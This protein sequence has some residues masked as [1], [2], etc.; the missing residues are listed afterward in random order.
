MPIPTNTQPWDEIF[1]REG[2]VFDSPAPVVHHVAD[3]FQEHRCRRVVDLGCGS[4]RHTVFLAQRGL[5]VI[6]ID[7]SPA[8]LNLSREWLTHEGLCAR[9]ARADMRQ[10]LP[11]S[12]GVCDAVISTQ[13]IHHALLATVR[14]TAR[15]ITRIL[16]PGGVLFVSMPSG[17][18][19]EDTFQEIEPGTFVPISGREAGLPHHIFSAEELESLFSGYTVLEADLIDERIR[20]LLAIRPA[21]N[22]AT[23]EV[24]RRRP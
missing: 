10:P 17:M 22:D 3:V 5:D 20:T 7:S 15:E 8:A 6:G 21:E 14:G 13:V 23:V 19:T 4:G 11:L 18:D 12:G 2:R 16:R 1:R 24:A 9:L